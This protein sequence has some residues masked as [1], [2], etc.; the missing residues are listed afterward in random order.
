MTET[1]TSFQ[2]VAP[3]VVREANDRIMTVSICANPH[4]VPS[5]ASMLKEF[6]ELSHGD[7]E[8]LSFVIQH[9][10]WLKTGQRLFSTPLTREAIELAAMNAMLK[11]K[12]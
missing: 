7:T 11:V 2:E 9:V 12:K 4:D 3:H 1:H 5:F 8:S 10:S 6:E